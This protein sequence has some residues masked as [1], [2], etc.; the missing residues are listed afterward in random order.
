MMATVLALRL[1]RVSHQAAPNSES[2]VELKA[3]SRRYDTGC[4]DANAFFPLRPLFFCCVKR[5]SRG[6]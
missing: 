5:K 4:R 6:S 1:A 2:A 3:L